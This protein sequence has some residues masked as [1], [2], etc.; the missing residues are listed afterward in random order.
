MAKKYKNFEE[1]RIAIIV[2]AWKDPEFKAKLLKNP[3]AA[4]K[5]MGVELADAMEVRVVEDKADTFTFILPKAAANVRELSDRDLQKLA[6]GACQGRA[7]RETGAA[8]AQTRH[9]DMHGGDREA[10][11]ERLGSS[12]PG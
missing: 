1:A 10:C 6:G 3:R 11:I 2:R 5:E 9:V 8:M 7:G 4:F 12:G